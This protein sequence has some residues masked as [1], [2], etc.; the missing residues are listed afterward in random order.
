M[1]P[2]TIPIHVITNER[3]DAD[4]WYA[5]ACGVLLAVA[6]A[7]RFRTL[8]STLFED[9][10]WVAELV[11]NGGW[12]GHSWSTP[13]LFYA[14]CRGWTSVL[15]V[16]NAALREP[17]AIFGVA[18]CA[19]PL[20]APLPRVSR[21][22][23]SALLAFSSPLLFYSARVKQYTLEA[24]AVT[25]LIVLFLHIK[26]SESII[27]T[28]AFFTIGAIAVTTLYSPVFVL[29]PMAILCIRRP[30]LLGGFAL[31]FALF[32]LAYIRWLAPGPESIRLH[33][34]MNA[35]FA[36]NGR[37]ITSPASFIAGTMHWSGQAMNL[38]RFWWLAV[39]LLILTWLFRE[40]NLV[41]TMLALLPPLVAA[42]ASTIHRYPYGEVRLMIF[43]LPALYLLIADSMASIGRRM[44][45]LLLLLAPFVWNGVARDSY[46][47]TYM[48]VDDLRPMF[49][50][51]VRSHTPGQAIYAN[52]SFAASLRYECPSLAADIHSGT[53]STMTRP[54][55]YI[56]CAPAFSSGSAGVTMHIGNVIAARSAP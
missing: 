49:D 56:Q 25:V 40:R 44:P 43:C 5:I 47:E 50:M 15:G 12:H 21:F 48:H 51:I 52:P 54:G 39:A 14:I 13:P 28:V 7:I 41:I 32:A 37:W 26:R 8:G 2:I 24:F 19:V 20:V 17:A 4:L 10:V 55:W 18:V 38:V 35:Y 11:R 53:E 36:A 45:L 27:P 42:V 23:W 6:A 3:D 1:I 34:D 16:S 30:R 29:V 46:N 31:L 22:A 9:E 33:G